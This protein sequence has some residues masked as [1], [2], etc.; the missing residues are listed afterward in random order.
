[1][2]GL[3]NDPEYRLMLRLAH[4]LRFDFAAIKSDLQFIIGQ[5]TRVPRPRVAQPDVAARL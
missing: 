3:A 2:P 4:R 5:L 1:M